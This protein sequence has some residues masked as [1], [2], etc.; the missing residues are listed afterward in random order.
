MA[1]R[2]DTFR[3]TI[4]RKWYKTETRDNYWLVVRA[5]KPDPKGTRIGPVQITG[6]SWYP[7]AVEL[8]RERNL[9]ILEKRRK[10]VAQM[11]SQGWSHD[12]II[13]FKEQA[14]RDARRE[15][16][17]ENYQEQEIGCQF[18]SDDTGH[19]GISRGP[20]CSLIANKPFRPKEVA[21]G[22][23]L[24]P[25]GSGPKKQLPAEA[26]DRSV[27]EAGKRDAD[28][29]EQ[30]AKKAKRAK[31]E[32]TGQKAKQPSAGKIKSLNQMIRVAVAA[33][34]QPMA[35]HLIVE[36]R[37][38][39][40]K[41]F[42]LVEGTKR[43]IG[44]G[45][46]SVVGTAQQDAIWKEI[47]KGRKPSSTTF[48]AFNKSIATELGTKVPKGC[49]ARTVHSLGFA[50][51][52]NA[53]GS[54][55]VVD[56]DKTAILLG[57]H[58]AKDHWELRRQEPLYVQSV[59]KLVNL[60]KLTL[61]DA[62][63]DGLQEL[64]NRYDVEVNGQED[65]V[66]EAVASV[67]EKSRVTTDL[68]DYSDMP[69]LP[70]VNGYPVMQ[71]DLLMVD[72]A[73]D[74]GRCQQALIQKAGKRLILCGDP[75]QA[76]YG[77]AGADT[78]SMPR[79]LDILKGERG[80]GHLFLTMTRRCCKAVVRL[81]Q[82]IVPDFEAFPENPE[83]LVDNPTLQ[84]FQEKVIA[85]D[86]VLCRVNA[87]LV[88]HCFRLIRDGKKANIQ[89]RDIGENLVNL[90]QRLRA[91]NTEQFV[92]ALDEYYHLE[93]RKLAFR[94]GDTEAAMIALA[95]KRDCLLAVA[96]GAKTVADIVSRIREIFSDSCPGVL[97]S[98]V[99]RAKGLE[100]NRVWILEPH[101]M[102][103][104]M[105]KSRWQ[106]DQEANLAYVAITRAKNDLRIV[107]DLPAVSVLS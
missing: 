36:A 85:G 91:N 70:V 58:E 45:T 40:G 15:L 82:R 103:H 6:K 89:G 48:L 90:V 12:D 31:V 97:L 46:P 62:T 68:I 7:R 57:Y 63:P 37:A 26:K 22:E 60:C 38:G 81:A 95:D 87:P 94:K 105:A 64:S 93:S 77:F 23:T 43:A 74:L 42:T 99:H 9:A 17:D 73:Q 44:S 67:L 54:S 80:C 56:K 39:T 35:E 16:G 29:V 66:F 104:P 102:P 32:V 14:L 11:L 25:L 18:N 106:R 88:Q 61:T 34:Y 3:N 96:D 84:T 71:S 72:E 65:R 27:A 19:G 53:V 100:A 1:P 69:W 98:S 13:A 8:A 86:M 52:T 79:M 4:F 28:L 75:R 55:V 92:T 78:E 5:D 76:I 101:L 33:S 107:G 30:S 51:I 24:H 47:C 83:G 59:V 21:M 20:L 10:I 2:L 49:N 50:S 41:T